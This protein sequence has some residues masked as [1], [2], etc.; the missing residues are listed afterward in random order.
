MRRS[1]GDLHSPISRPHSGGRSMREGTVWLL[2][3]ASL[4]G[5]AARS[6]AQLSRAIVARPDNCAIAR[7]W[8]KATGE[9]LSPKTASATYQALS[10]RWNIDTAS[11]VREITTFLARSPE[12]LSAISNAANACPRT[13]C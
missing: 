5:G 10:T 13:G 8:A 9:L 3:L 7:P 4:V 2:A 12:V 11:T 1:T 6:E